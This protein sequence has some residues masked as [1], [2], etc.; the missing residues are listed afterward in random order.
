MDYIEV[1]S[2][3]K[4]MKKYARRSPQKAVLLLAVV[5]LYDSGVL[6]ENMIEYDEQ[7]ASAYLRLWN[8]LLPDDAMLLPEM[9]QTFWAMNTEDFW[10]IV[11]QR[12]K[13]EVVENIRKLQTVPSDATIRD[14]VRYVELDEDLYV[15]MTLPSGR[16][17]LKEALLSNYFELSEAEYATLSK[18]NDSHSVEEVSFNRQHSSLFDTFNAT[19]SCESPSYVESQP[20]GLDDDV[21]L[22]MCVTYYKYVKRNGLSRGAFCE[23]FPSPLSVYKFIHKK[24]VALSIQSPSLETFVGEFLH[25]L[26]IAL[27]SDDNSGAVIGVIDDVLMQLEANQD[28]A[29]GDGEVTMIDIDT[30]ANADNYS[31][32]PHDAD[33]SDGYVQPVDNDERE[34]TEQEEARL[35]FAHEKGCSLEDLAGFLGR[36]TDFITTKMRELGF[37]PQVVEENPMPVT[38]VAMGGDMSQNCGEDFFVENSS[39]S[40]AIFDREYRKIYTS[41]GKLKVFGGRPYLIRY[42]YSHLSCNLL[43]RDADGKFH[44]STRIID[45]PFKSPLFKSIDQYSYCDSIWNLAFDDVTLDWLVYVNGAWY[46]SNGDVANLPTRVR[47]MC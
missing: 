1:L 2:N 26:K 7:L 18:V 16:G 40:C 32:A 30:Q 9:N 45:A 37:M 29:L 46:A 33:A 11:P 27:M 34:W 36:S 12:G 35:C 23:Q 17:A 6:E 8:Q 38:S 42:A 41:R 39:G 14:C 24:D 20:Q 43:E 47:A 28:V 22:T 25:E 3:L 5:E 4:P 13:E 19:V 44:T 31:D 15:M 10:H 21:W